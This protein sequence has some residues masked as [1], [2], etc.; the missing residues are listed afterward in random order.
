MTEISHHHQEST[1]TATTTTTTTARK[2]QLSS[3][4]QE[5]VLVNPA[6]LSFG[7]VVHL[8]ELEGKLP[9]RKQLTEEGGS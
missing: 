4:T 8:A 9:L 7:A 2:L 1:T 5:D 6:A 3:T